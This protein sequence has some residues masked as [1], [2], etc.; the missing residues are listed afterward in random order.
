MNNHHPIASATRA[1]TVP[2]SR[3]RFLATAAGLAL[4]P[5]LLHLA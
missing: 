4:V 1:G 2:I 3:E 5:A